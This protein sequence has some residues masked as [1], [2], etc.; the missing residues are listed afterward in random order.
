MFS[1]TLKVIVITLVLFQGH[2]MD[3]LI[4]TYV[5]YIMNTHI[6]KKPSYAGIVVGESI[7]W[8][9][10]KWRQKGILLRASIFAGWC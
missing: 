6:K 10:S 4:M 1:W 2:N 8:L 9:T 3:D 7:C 5:A